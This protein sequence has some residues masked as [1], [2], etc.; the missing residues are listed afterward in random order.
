MEKKYYGSFKDIKNKEIF[1][2]ITPSSGTYTEEVELKFPYETPVII[3]RNSDGIFTPIKD[4]AATITIFTDEIYWDIYDKSITGAYVKIYSV[5]DNNNEFIYFVGY[6]TPCIYTQDYAYK[7]EIEL[8][9]VDF[10]AVLDSYDY[11]VEG[12][13]DII[14][15]DE[16]LNK[17]FSR[18]PNYGTAKYVNDVTSIDFTKYYVQEAN[19]FDDDDEPMTC[20]DILQELLNYCGI[21]AT[22]Y[23]GVIHFIDYHNETN[24]VDDLLSVS[25]YGEG[26]PTIELDEVYNKIYI[27]NDLY[28]LDK[29]VDDVIDE[30]NKTITNELKIATNGV[31]VKCDYGFSWREH[32]HHTKP[33]HN[34]TMLIKPYTFIDNTIDQKNAKL[35]KWKT[36]SR[37]ISD[38]L[39]TTETTIT[40]RASR[41]CGTYYDSNGNPLFVPYYT[42]AYPIREYCYTKAEDIKSVAKINWNDYILFPHWSAA[43]ED[44]GNKTAVY[45]ALEFTNNNK[46]AYSLSSGTGYIVINGGLYLQSQIGLAG[47]P[48]EELIWMY[49][50]D[51]NGNETKICNP[52]CLDNCDIRVTEGY[53]YAATR[54]SGNDNYNKGWNLI[55]AK[56]QIGDK[57]WDGTKWTTANTIFFIPFHDA[58]VATEK[59]TLSYYKW[60]EV[61]RNTNVIQ[62][63]VGKEGY[64]I[65]ITP[66]DQINGRLIFTLYT[67]S[68][69]QAVGDARQ[70]P[71][72]FMRDLTVE[73]A[74]TGIT[75]YLDDEVADEDIV[76][77]NEWEEDDLTVQDMDELDL[78]INSYNPKY[79]KPI[80]KSYLLDSRKIPVEQYLNRISADTFS[81]KQEENL[82]YRYYSHYHTPKK[83][84]NINYK[85]TDIPPLLR[86][87][88]FQTETKYFVDEYEMNLKTG[89]TQL[90]LIEL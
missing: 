44:K 34:Y 30:D 60:L 79:T 51:K 63:S 56:L 68:I 83:I 76:Y 62:A 55:K 13:R 3:E 49:G 21:T 28:E 64:A 69:Y 17:I 77:E 31:N 8:E 72:Y 23:N 45:P 9:A 10:L 6:L 38:M 82:I 15:I 87:Q 20:K 47:A 86:Y 16:L 89:E 35:S 50:Y 33:E 53:E 42:G 61:A 37:R 7:S 80:S 19:F 22:M 66:T 36:F 75:N 39:L 1:V 54:N 88:H 71:N 78:K 27:G 81:T 29:V 32:G 52:V 84:L 73:Y 74:Y 70:I 4:S 40:D 46:L 11:V 18:I 58:N 26:T 48:D 2:E 24:R 65:P 57:F 14:T 12:D 41:D 85:V 90:K 59:E 25:K 5:D 67:P 43:N